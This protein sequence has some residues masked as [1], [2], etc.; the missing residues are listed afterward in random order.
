[1]LME[2]DDEF[3]PERDF[4]RYIE[5]DPRIREWQDLMA[6]MQEP[7][8]GAAP[9]ELWANMDAG[10]RAVSALGRSAPAVA[11]AVRAAADRR[12]RRRQHRA[13][14]ASAGV[15]AARLPGRRHLRRRCSGGARAGARRSASRACSRRS[16]KRSR[17]PARSSTS[18]CRRSTS[19]ASS[20][21]MPAG[22]A[23]LMQK[24]MG[25]DLDDARR[26]RAICRER[27]LVAAVNFQ[28]RFAPNMLAL[29][30]ALDRAAARRRDGRGGAAEPAHAVGVLG[31]P[32]RRAAPRGADALHPLHRPDPLADRRAARRLLPRRA[33]SRRSRSTPTRARASSSTT[34]TWCAAA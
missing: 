10:V 9:G 19:R 8:P 25:R 12:H 20:S 16:T 17:R 28:L 31:V 29:R 3:E 6:S 15:R 7:R 22:A 2:T 26:I 27:K 5:S 1:M 34:A 23:V 13:R 32:R 21:A 11:A 14:R 4:A 30:D 24:P 33:P 18:P